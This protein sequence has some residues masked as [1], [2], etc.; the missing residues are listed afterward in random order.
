MSNATPAPVKDSAPNTTLL[1]SISEGEYN[2]NVPMDHISP[3]PR[4]RDKIDPEKVKSL[5]ASILAEG[6]LQPPVLRVLKDG[7]Y[8]L[9]AGEHRWRAY[10]LLKRET[11]PAR[12]Y[13]NE[14]ELSAARKKSVEN[15]QRVALTPIEE[16]KKYRELADL[17]MKQ[18]EIGDLLGK[19]QPVVANAMR[20]LELS[21]DVQRFL[22]VNDMS[23]AHA[24]ALCR[25]KAW[26]KLCLAIAELAEKKGSPAKELNDGLPFAEELERAKLVKELDYTSDR[27]ELPKGFREHPDIMPAAPRYPDEEPYL[28]CLNYEAGKAI[29]AAMEAERKK[30]R[31]ERTPSSGRTENGKMT[32]A[33]KAERKKVIIGN[34]RKRAET[35]ATLDAG[36]KRLAAVKDVDQRALAVIVNEALRANYSGSRV[37][38]AAKALGVSVPKGTVISSWTSV[39]SLEKLRQI[40]AV[41]LIRVTGLAIARTHGENALRGASECPAVV[42]LLAAGK[43]TLP[44]EKP[45]AVAKPTKAKP[46]K[47]AAITDATR[48]LVK[49]HFEAGRTGADTAKRLGI[50]LPSVQNIKKALGLVAPRK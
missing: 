46:P 27:E 15:F 37:A 45:K 36:V 1:K 22:G 25:F 24:V 44:V 9:I 17:G 13:R 43:K 2:G 35:Q 49:Q 48:L 20:I 38:E 11:I 6:L 10:K 7:K 23:M 47:R 12:I 14:T 4:N 19:S 26:P 42:A 5:A 18:A 16:A 29:I 34:K 28:Y 31:E 41:D 21:S 8:Q 33:A 3:D 39:I 30:E 32:E 40:P 50:S